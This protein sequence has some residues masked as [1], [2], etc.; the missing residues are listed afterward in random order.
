MPDRKI[1]SMVN[2]R[3]YEIAMQMVPGIKAF[4][5]ERVRFEQD[6]AR[7]AGESGVYQDQFVLEALAD[8]TVEDALYDIRAKF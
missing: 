3:A 1:N 4:L 7:R 8:S 6:C 5:I 2:R